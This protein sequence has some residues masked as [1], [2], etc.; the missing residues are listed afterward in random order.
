[1]SSMTF[2]LPGITKKVLE[3]ICAHGEIDVLITEAQAG[4]GNFHLTGETEAVQ[5]LLD[6]AKGYTGGVA[7][8]YSSGAAAYFSQ[9]PA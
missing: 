7:R 9:Y 8:V 4:G 2:W 3:E 6:E 1:M 5:Q